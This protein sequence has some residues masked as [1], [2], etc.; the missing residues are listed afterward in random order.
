[1]NSQ[2][3]SDKII[4]KEKELENSKDI[5]NLLKEQILNLEQINF[6]N[7][8]QKENFEL[9]KKNLEE[10]IEGQ[11]N[12]MENL[13]NKINDLET[14]IKIKDYEIKS[15]TLKLEETKKNINN[16]KGKF[17][18]DDENII[19]DNNTIDYQEKLDYEYLLGNRIE[20]IRFLRFKIEARK[21]NI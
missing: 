14:Q 4:E 15:I 11:S 19:N 5:I 2:I 16:Q 12:D 6:S 9:I 18:I 3:H 20:R 13:K 21:K 8:H 17:S 1:M 7:N 10:I